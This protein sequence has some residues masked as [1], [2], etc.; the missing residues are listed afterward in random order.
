MELIG[1]FDRIQD[2]FLQVLLDIFKTSDIVPADIRNFNNSLTKRRRITLSQGKLEVIV[3]NSHGVQNSGIDGLIFNINDI[4]LF[5]DTLQGSFG[6]ELGKIG[7]DETMSFLRD[8]GKFDIFCQFHVLGVNSQNFHSTGFIRN[9]DIDFTIETTESSQCS[10]DSVR[11]VGGSNANNLSSSLKTIHKS[12]QL[13]N[14]SLF[15]FTVGLVSLGSNG[16]D[17][18]N[19]D[20]S[21]GILLGFFEGLSQVRFGFTSHLTHNLGTIDQEK[22][23]TS[24]VGNSSGDQSLSTTGRTVQQNSTRRFHS[25]SFEKS[26]MSQGQLDHF[27]NLSHL[28]SASSNIIISDIIQS[29]FVF[30]LDGFSFVEQ[31]GVGS[32]NT[33]FSRFGL[34]NLKFNRSE[35]TSDQEQIALTDRS[36]GILEIGDQVGAGQI[37]SQ[38][39]DGVID[40]Q[41][42][43]SVTVG[44]ISTRVNTDNISKSDTEIFSDHFVHSDL[45]VFEIFVGQGDTDSVV[46]FFTLQNDGISSEDFQFVHFSL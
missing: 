1:M 21:R 27:T 25:Q 46:S 3:G 35:T 2:H 36:V 14:N 43:N 29:I 4:H 18:I 10:I 30:S 26:G 39:F 41:N 40:G 11:S 38:A 23:G 32:N 22:E 9:T 13:G 45:L 7:S 33:V 31:H 5:S 8:T 28:S 37:S 44:D 42:V 19:E 34:D 15:D 24:F 20:N 6:T 16:I 12:Q 17:F